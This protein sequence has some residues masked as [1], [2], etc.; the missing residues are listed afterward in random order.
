MQTVT[1]LV[2]PVAV[3]PQDPVLSVFLLMVT[4]DADDHC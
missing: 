2:R 4:H 1:N 3:Y